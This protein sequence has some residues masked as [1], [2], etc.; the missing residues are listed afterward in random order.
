M[1]VRDF[2][3]TSIC[4]R[5]AKGTIHLLKYG[6]IRREIIGQKTIYSWT[7]FLKII[8]KIL[9]NTIIACIFKKIFKRLIHLLF[10]LFQYNRKS[11]V[12]S[13]FLQQVVFR[14]YFYYM[15]VIIAIIS[16]EEQYLIV[17]KLQIYQ[18]KRHASDLWDF[19]V[20]IISK[21]SSTLI[22]CSFLDQNFF[23]KTPTVNY[24]QIISSQLLVNIVF[25]TVM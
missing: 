25:K 7:K 2:W 17:K 6:N 8:W 5:S 20:V 1:F 19:L 11:K 24:T 9:T 14:F 10:S 12:Q 13:N 16:S 4:T 22:C 23:T 15:L 21:Y 3:H 18:T